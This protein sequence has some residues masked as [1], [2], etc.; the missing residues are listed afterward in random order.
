MTQAHEGESQMQT[1][2]TSKGKE[3]AVKR[4]AGCARRSGG[5]LHLVQRQ[6]EVLFR[7]YV[8]QHHRQ[9]PSVLHGRVHAALGLQEETKCICLHPAWCVRREEGGEGPHPGLQCVPLLYIAVQPPGVK[10]QLHLPQKAVVS[11][12]VVVP[13]GDLQAA[14]LQLRVADDVLLDTETTAGW[15]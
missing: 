15:E 13:H 7:R 4:Q 14:R 1:D 5:T 12:A 8:L 9:L 2:Q 11:K 6:H 10:G 3:F